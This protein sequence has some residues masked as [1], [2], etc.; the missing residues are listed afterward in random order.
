MARIALLV[1]HRENRRLLAEWLTLQNHVIVN[2]DSND[3]DMDYDLVILDAVFLDQ[4]WEQIRHKKAALEPLFLPT[5]L[6]TSRHDVGLL[7]RQLWQTVDELIFAPVEKVEL[8][9]RIEILIRT[10]RLS[11]ALAQANQ[12]L[13]EAN[14]QK[15]KFLGMISHELRTPLASIKG[16]A[17]TLLA[18][19]VVWDAES[20]HN[21]IGIIDTEADKLANMVEQLLDLSRMQ[22]GML[23]IR[24]Q[25]ESF[26]SVIQQ[27]R[28]QLDTL[29][30]NHVIVTDIPSTLPPVWIDRERI[31]QV[32]T[33]LVGNA[34]KYSLPNTQ[35]VVSASSDQ[36]NVQVD[37]SDQGQGIPPEDRAIVFE[38]F[39]QL[40]RKTGGETKGAGLGL[41][42]CKALVETHGG[43]IWVQDHETPG[44]TI[45]FTLPIANVSA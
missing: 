3:F 4:I 38:A 45:S 15:L 40:D 2:D 35:I 36:E 12:E 7:T 18:D 31:A 21:F 14:F 41:A 10:R 6:I 44:T 42:I 22:S 17:S 39:R 34:V 29:T 30:R 28:A 27:A 9:A 43:R 13:Q 16:F 5:L 23:E 1:N 24:K 19:D 32:L 11:L 37:V 25:I 8:L 20:Q 26:D 33:N